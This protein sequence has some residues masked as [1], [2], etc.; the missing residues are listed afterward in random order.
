MSYKKNGNDTM[1]MD[2]NRKYLRL[3]A[4]DSIKEAES[5]RSFSFVLMKSG[6]WG[7]VHTRDRLYASINTSK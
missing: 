6:H 5:Q 7:M 4:H 2:L 1:L 3:E